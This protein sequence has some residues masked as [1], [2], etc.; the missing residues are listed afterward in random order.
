MLHTTN[1]QK[2]AGPKTHQRLAITT[3]Q[4]AC[5]PIAGAVVPAEFS[6]FLKSA[7]RDRVAYGHRFDKEFC[8]L[9]S[10]VHRAAMQAART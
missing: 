7:L 9:Q 10:I 6:T 8:T 3:R 4:Y 2:N 5:N 1:Q